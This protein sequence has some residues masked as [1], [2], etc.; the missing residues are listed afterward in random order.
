MEPS[1]PTLKA[2]FGHAN[3]KDQMKYQNLNLYTAEV[4]FRCAVCLEYQE[5]HILNLPQASTRGNCANQWRSQQTPAVSHTYKWPSV[6]VCVLNKCVWVWTGSWVSAR[7]KVTADSCRG[8]TSDHEPLGTHFLG[9]G[10]PQ[11]ASSKEL[12]LLCT[13]KEPTKRLWDLEM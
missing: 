1:L 11:G 9:W 3:V 10:G 7:R 2:F 12:G 6:K 5:I 13:S 8:G 4:L